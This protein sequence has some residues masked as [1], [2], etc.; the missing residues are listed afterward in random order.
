LRRFRLTFIDQIA[1]PLRQTGSAL[2]R[3]KLRSALTIL[4]IS[5]GVASMVLVS[6][7]CGGFREGQRQ[8]IA[9]FGEGMVT[10]WG[11]R[12]EMQ[13]GGRRAGR[14]IILTTDDAEA[15]RQQCTSVSA[16]AGQ[17]T[18]PR[19]EVSGPA[20]SARFDVL[21]V[22]PEYLAIRSLPVS[23]G[24][25]IRWLDVERRG[26][27]C[28]LGW[29]AQDRLFDDPEQALDAEITLNG[30]RYRVVGVRGRLGDSD[31]RDGIDD[32]KLLVPLTSLRRDAPPNTTA[33][34]TGLLSSLVYRPVHLESSGEAQ[35]QVQR[36]LAR[37]H[38]FRTED[39]GALRFWDTQQSART[40]NS[41]VNSIEVFL[42]VVAAI[43][44]SLGGVSVMN[45]MMISVTERTREIGLKKAVGATRRRVLLEVLVEGIALTLIGGPVGI[46]IVVALAPL[47]NA[48]PMSSLFAGLT[49]EAR[50]GIMA[51]A[52]LGTVGL[53]SAL[54]PA[55]RAS[56][57]TPV[58]ALREMT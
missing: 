15:I 31:A 58:E 3:H 18:T 27:V 43:T 54:P 16:V 49:L 44:L 26:R 53:L 30:V 17:L 28:V 41:I 57:L 39:A 50:S 12:T 10:V 6:S 9:Q 46:F 21:G 52:A 13:A 29:T 1:T 25:Q 8:R 55:W 47:V 56:R 4:C 40:F 33:K 32:D 5:W 34:L 51:T 36:T 2:A 24:R 35:L 23:R 22:D 7:I 38:G 42:L 11:G 20:G 48:V 19:V 45:I 14:D 37:R